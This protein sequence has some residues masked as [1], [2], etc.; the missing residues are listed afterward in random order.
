MRASYVSYFQSQYL[1]GPNQGQQVQTPF[2]TYGAKFKVVAVIEKSSTPT[3]P[4]SWT[5]VA[6]TKIT[7]VLNLS[8]GGFT[9]TSNTNEVK[10]VPLLGLGKIGRAHV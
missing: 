1:S 7:D 3:A 5:Y 10:M 6:S 4:N 8:N 2:Y 9:Y